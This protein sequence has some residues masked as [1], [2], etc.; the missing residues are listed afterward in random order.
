MGGMEIVVPLVSPEQLVALEFQEVK[1]ILEG[2]DLTEV[3]V[4]LGPQAHPDLKEM[5]ESL[6]RESPDQRDPKVILDP[7]G[8]QDDQVDQELEVTMEVQVP[9][10]FPETK[11][12]VV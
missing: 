7:V 3:M 5:L 2:T 12:R 9:L 10:D 6:E 11:D 8:Y 1:E 4:L